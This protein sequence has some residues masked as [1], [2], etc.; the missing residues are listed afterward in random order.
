MADGAFATY[1]V[2]VREDGSIRNQDRDRGR[3]P[4]ALAGTGQGRERRP[5][6]QAGWPQE[7]DAER[8][9]L[10]AARPEALSLRSGGAGVASSPL[11]AGWLC[12]KRPQGGFGRDTRPIDGTCGAGDTGA[13]GGAPCH[14]CK[15]GSDR[16]CAGHLARLG[17]H[18][19]HGS[20]S[21]KGRT[22][23]GLARFART[24]PALTPSHLCNNP[25]AIAAPLNRKG[26]PNMHFQPTRPMAHQPKPPPTCTAPRARH[27]GV[28]RDTQGKERT[29]ND[30]MTQRPAIGRNHKETTRP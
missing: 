9:S 3:C 26:E 17:H 10:G 13:T 28:H 14:Y 12:P 18:V 29:M 30:R 4:A 5:C 22:H 8:S 21:D 19:S 25:R 7:R 11:V 2:H 1:F 27:G 20:G 23:K 15:A 6:S 24:L 16:A